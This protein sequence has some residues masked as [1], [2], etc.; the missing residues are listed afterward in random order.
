MAV[1]V[2]S[3]ATMGALVPGTETSAAGRGTRAWYGDHWIDLARDWETATACSVGDDGAFCFAT[4]AEMDAYLASTGSAV[5]VAAG[6]IT[7]ALSCAS[8]LRLYDGTSYTGSAL[9][10]SARG[11]YLNLSSYGFDNRTSSYKVGACDSYFYSGA[12]G[13]GALY[14]IGNTQAFDQFTSMLVGWNNTVSS[15]YIT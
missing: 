8:S 2:V 14:P 3:L 15:V 9:H 5:A 6:P 1:I 4:E 13:S 10:L 12:S 7:L 11:T